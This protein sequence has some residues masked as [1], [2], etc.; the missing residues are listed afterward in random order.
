M[1]TFRVKQSDGNP[2]L[3]LL[4]YSDDYE[5][6]PGVLLTKEDA[7]RL[8]KALNDVANHTSGGEITLEVS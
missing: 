2:N 7:R 4:F 6:R 1:P 5:N 8:G 3:V